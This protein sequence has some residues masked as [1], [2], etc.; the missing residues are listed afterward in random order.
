MN[1]FDQATG[2]LND[3]NYS[4]TGF[5]MH[6]L[7]FS[8]AFNHG[9]A[10]N[11]V[12]KQRFE[13][14][15]QDKMP[16]T[17]NY[18]ESEY[19]NLA[20]SSI[21]TVLD[22]A[23]AFNFDGKNEQNLDKKDMNKPFQCPHAGCG[24]RFLRNHDLNKHKK[25]HSGEKPFVCPIC[26]KAFARKDNL[27]S[28]VKGHAYH[29]QHPCDL[30]DE[31]LPHF[32]SFKEH[33]EKV[34]YDD[35]ECGFESQPSPTGSLNDGEQGSSSDA[36]FVCRVGKCNQRFT[37]Q[38]SFTI[39]ARSHIHRKVFQCQTCSH[40]FYKSANLTAHMRVHT[41]ERPFHCE[42]CGL[43]FARKAD[44]DRHFKR[45]HSPVNNK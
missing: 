10:I 39:H 6:S 3:Y 2:S 17:S 20:D 36:S 13:N 18:Q 4:N 14:D 32:A 33:M 24:K 37:K 45:Q 27:S 23:L 40:I 38:S 44:R 22:F 1:G 15:E 25:L 21:P 43:M 26:Q 28:H 7:D 19:N 42:N 16:S 30:C 31:I 41:G 8:D 34:H 9:D 35:I 11:E 29:K 12:E 5:H